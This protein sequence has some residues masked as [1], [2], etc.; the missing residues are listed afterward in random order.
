MLYGVQKMLTMAITTT[1]PK[2]T[3]PAMES[4]LRRKR[5]QA[6]CQRLTCSGAIE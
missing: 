6:S 3:M 1:S 4:L 5:R 2:T